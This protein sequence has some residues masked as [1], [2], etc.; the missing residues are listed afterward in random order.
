MVTPL[1]R[2]VGD[3]FPDE[4]IDKVCEADPLPDDFDLEDDEPI[5]VGLPLTPKEI[6]AACVE[7]GRWQ[8]V[9]TFSSAE[10]PLRLRNADP[11]FF[12]QPQL[13]FLHD[14]YVLA[15]FAAR[16]GADQ[17]RLADRR[18][19]W[20]DGFVR[21]SKHT[22]KVEVTSTHGERKLG[23]EYREPRGMRFDPVEAWHARADS[24]PGY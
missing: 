17:V 4:C 23:E 12:L 21:V 9:E 19:Q 15:K 22:I 6:E 14:A 5:P 11:D 10:R 18:D 13:K 3:N 8:S 20:P 7:L 16:I 24:I 2:P 1:S